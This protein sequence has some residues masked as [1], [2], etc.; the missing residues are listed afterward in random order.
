MPK[1]YY[2]PPPPELRPGST[3]WAYLRDSGGPTQ[4]RSVE[5]QREVLIEYCAKH[6]LALNQIFADI[7]K[8]GTSDE[9][10]EEFLEMVDLTVR[11]ASRPHGILFWSSARIARNTLDAQYHRST[12]RKRGIIVHALIDEIPTGKFQIA[13]EAMLDVANQEKAEQ[14]SRESRRGLQHIVRNYGAVSGPAPTGIMRVPI[15]IISTDGTKRTLHRWEP[16]P[17]VAPRVRQAFEMR[18]NGR[19]LADIN[20]ATGLF[21]SLNSYRTFWPNKIY[22]GIL[23]FGDLVIENY[24]DPIV[25]RETWDAVQEISKK[26]TKHEHM[27]D[28]LNHPRRV[29]SKFLLSGLCR[30]A[31]CESPMWGQ[32]SPQRNGGRIEAYRCTRAHRRRDCDLPRIPAKEF[33]SVVLQALIKAF[34]QPELY[35]EIHR[36]ADAKRATW[37]EKKLAKRRDLEANLRGLRRAAK[38][39]SDAIGKMGYSKTLAEQLTVN[40]RQQTA[41]ELELNEMR[42][43]MP[44]QKTVSTDTELAAQAVQ[45][46]K[47]LHSKDPQTIKDI[48]QGIVVQI[49]VNREDNRIFGVITIGSEDDSSLPKIPPRGY[50]SEP[51]DKIIASEDAVGKS[52]HPSGPPRFYIQHSV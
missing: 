8:T 40:E 27:K 19:S 24:C 28:E 4:D 43:M 31:R 35:I 13:F 3:V 6:G 52:L 41:L 10:R 33:E 36:Q 32:T 1:E 49:N 7:H 18:K 20:N 30:C 21:G 25:D 14:A 2:T 34:S 16:L 51:N 39:I 50:N 12:L 26:F 17:E 5:Q 15:E 45:V 9:D 47:A 23:E 46:A 29:S 37:Q 44:A 42:T 38:N 48:V 11:P 22:I